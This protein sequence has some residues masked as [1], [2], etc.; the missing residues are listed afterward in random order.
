ML[1][2]LG[3]R[4]IFCEVDQIREG[5]RIRGAVGHTQFFRK[6]ND[7]EGLTLG[8]QCQHGGEYT[9][10]GIV[11]KMLGAKLHPI[12]EQ[13][14]LVGV[15]KNPPQNRSLGVDGMRGGKSMGSLCHCDSTEGVSPQPPEEPLD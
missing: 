9:S 14:E 2:I 10:V 12:V 7:V 3:I 11:E 15:A 8:F 6:G 4:R 1:G 13:V 5:H